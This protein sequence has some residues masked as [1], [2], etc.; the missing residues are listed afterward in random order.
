MSSESNTF[1]LIYNM[2][3]LYE[4]IFNLLRAFQQATN[5]NTTQP[6][7]VT[8]K[9]S[10]GTTQ[11]V[12][13]NSFQQVQS[14]IN[15]LSN[16]FSALTNSNNLSYI[17]NADGTIT[18]YLRTSFI[19]AE[20]I[21]T[22]QIQVATTAI[23]DK[24]TLLADFLHPLVKIPITIDQTIR[25]PIVTRTFEISDG[26]DNVPD[27][28]SLVEFQN[29]VSGG[30]VIVS[31]EVTRE[32]SPYKEQVRFFGKFNVESVE[33][34]LNNSFRLVL[35]DL[36]YTGLNVNGNTIELRVGNQLVTSTGMSRYMIDNVYLQ[37]NTIDVTRV[38]GSE[39]PTVGINNLVFNQII[40]GD[41]IVVGIPIK[42]LQNLV[43]FFSSESFRSISFPSN[44]IKI[45][46]RDYRV[47]Y[48]GTTYTIDEFFSSY[49]TNI[50]EYLISMVEESA[51]PYSMGIRP[52]RPQLLASN[53]KVVQVNKHTINSNTI[54]EL[55]TWNA[56][57]AGLE[58]DINQK[59]RLI[60]N[61]NAEIE[62]SNYGTVAEKND[63]L[64]K[65]ENLRKEIDTNN[66]NIL[67]ISR[68]I[69][70]SIT[71]NSLRSIKPKYKVAGFWSIQNDLFS[72]MTG[73]QR[74]IKYEVQYRYLNPNSE[75]VDN[76]TLTM[77]DNGIEVSVVF[78]PWVNLDTITLTKTRSIDGKMVW[79]DL[80]SNSV[81]DININQCG[82]PIS[83][84]D[85][86]E[87]RIR[88]VSE[89]GYPISPLKSEWSNIIRVAFPEDLKQTNI[90]SVVRK[91]EIDLRIAE[92]NSILQERGI[93]SHISSQFV[94]A[95]KTYHHL[96]SF[97][98]SG[99]Y[100]DEMKHIPLDVA[101][102]NIIDS[103]EK[104]Q[105]AQFNP[106]TI[107][108][109]DVNGTE[110]PVSNDQV[111]KIFIGNYSEDIQTNRQL[112]N[113]FR[114]VT[115][116]TNNFGKIIQKK[117]YIRIRNNNN[118]PIDI[119]SLNPVPL[120]TSSGLEGIYSQV[121]VSTTKA[122]NKFPYR[123]EPGQIIYFRYTDLSL[124]QTNPVFAFYSPNDPIVPTNATGSTG[125]NPNVY[126]LNGSSP[127]Q[128][129]L[130]N[131][132][133]DLALFSSNFD[134]S[135]TVSD[136]QR[137]SRLTSVFSGTE[138]QNQLDSNGNLEISQLGFN[139]NDTFAI[140]QHTCGAFFYP[141]ISNFGK[142]SVKGDS[143][144][145]PLVLESNAEILIPLIFEYRMTDALGRI[146]GIA[147][148]QSTLDTIRVTKK[149]G[150]SMLVANQQFL[151]DIE[152]TAT[153]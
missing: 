35:N 58:N 130:P 57:K 39:Q 31:N 30:Q 72:P 52:A 73:V 69:E 50:S 17:L 76:T 107:E 118:I 112:N 60:H 54:S 123:Q 99:L 46:T 109:I 74:I 47:D 106:P 108:V 152:A 5:S 67:T 101:I 137:I 90:N 124:N 102:K 3:V 11:D 143:S 13:V 81:D 59:E 125:Q 126:V 135:P 23:V 128:I 113:T 8:L 24:K 26:Y 41:D 16:N 36:H 92:F 65:I 82:I 33:L 4:N 70:N 111:L 63:K 6:I 120:Q 148:N 22:D 45:S 71:N 150:I 44:G 37:S 116:I 78:S 140:G 86:V 149:L 105:N 80:R 53:F 129:Y 132:P 49:V 38:A 122:T 48:D 153:F 43:T 136:F 15:R 103:I 66:N 115:Q 20:Y 97:I 77:L 117:L 145:S 119:R 134:G 2:E 91:N 141:V 12:Q 62:S 89:A 32:L 142:I 114:R 146:M 18:N 10:D 121:P 61:L 68:R 42:P 151:F 93:L 51:I 9:N 64:T 7:T 29:L 144:V 104:L 83:E 25:A 79:Q 19:N 131:I 27:N 56:E 98:T 14:E 139:V 96:A 1:G 95:E 85:M 100:T 127:S 147:S 94:E 34:L 28:V 55:N 21:D 40:Q 84:I 133:D 87:I 138:K 110:Y 75:N 88:A